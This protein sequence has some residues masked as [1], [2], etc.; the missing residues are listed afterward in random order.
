MCQIYVGKCEEVTWQRAQQT[1]QGE[2]EGESMRVLAG[3]AGVCGLH[4]EY[5][6][7]LQRHL[8]EGTNDQISILEK[9]Y[10]CSME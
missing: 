7:T 5:H 10:S 4:P 6:G 2:K 9:I 8:A 1:P 3:L